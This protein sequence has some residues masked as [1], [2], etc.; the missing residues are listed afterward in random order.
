MLS[1]QTSS[2]HRRLVHEVGFGV[3]VGAGNE[4]WFSHPT[5]DTLT[6]TADGRCRGNVDLVRVL[7]AEKS[8]EIT[9]RTLPPEWDDGPMDCNYAQQLLQQYDREDR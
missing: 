4:I 3:H 6:A 1:H 7:S 8:L 5:G 9:P 2:R